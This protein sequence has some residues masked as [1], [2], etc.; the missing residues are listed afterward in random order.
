MEKLKYP[1][2]FSKCPNCGSERCI[3]EIETNNEI[4]KGNL[5]P[6]VRIPILVTESHLIDKSKPLKEAK[7]FTALVGYYDVCADCGT[8][9]CKR[10][11]K[12][13][14]TATPQPRIQPTRIMPPGGF[15]NI[16]FMG[17]G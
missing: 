7:K 4:E 12:V 5:A 16:P 14:G 13:E 10:I 11:N 17:K 3:V 15:G 1:I 6:G 9:Y 2:T 8:L